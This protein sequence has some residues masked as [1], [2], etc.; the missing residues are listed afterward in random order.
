MMEQTCQ[1]SNVTITI[2]HNTSRPSISS[3]PGSESGSGS[4]LGTRQRK[5]GLHGRARIWG[6][7]KTVRMILLTTAL[8]GR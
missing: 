7:N 8:M 5:S 1:H 4:G 6:P 2:D 3:G